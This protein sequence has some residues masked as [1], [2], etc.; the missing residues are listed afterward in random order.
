VSA[1]L[2]VA[3]V[4]TA[5]RRNRILDA[6]E[7]CFVRNGFH[8]TTMNDVAAEAGMSAGNLYRYF[9][10]K[11][12]I[13]RGLTERDREML[14]AEFEQAAGNPDVF[15]TIAAL[16]RRHLAEQ[17]REKAILVVEIWSEASRNPKIALLCGTIDDAI[18]HHLTSMLRAAQARGIVSATADV[19]LAVQM[20]FTFADG[21][22]KRRALEP[23]FD[24]EAGVAALSLLL[25]SLLQNPLLPGPSSSDLT[26]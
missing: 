6:A 12:A 18:R 24:G 15:G 3:R 19:P 1:P 13:V 10:S 9:E 14:S 17:P 16:A 26:A 21:L 5:E 4:S 22:F 11:E 25:R 23:D 8:R 2:P 7:S 20:L